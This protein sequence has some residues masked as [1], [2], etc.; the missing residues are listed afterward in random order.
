MLDPIW[1]AVLGVLILITAVVAPKALKCEGGKAD[2]LLTNGLLKKQAGDFSEAEYLLKRALAT[3]ESEKKPD[4]AKRCTCLVHLANCYEKS[5]SYT[6]ARQLYEKLCSL[7]LSVISKDDPD[8]FLDIDYLASTADFGSG[9][10]EI[11]DCYGAIVEAKKQVFGP[12]HPDV[13]NSLLIHSRLLARL[14]RKDEAEK[15]ELEAKNSPH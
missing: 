9:T 14:G 8:V 11:A 5:G 3:F 13:A 7:W 6:E 4:F 12:K 1:L 15:L 2:E 10:N